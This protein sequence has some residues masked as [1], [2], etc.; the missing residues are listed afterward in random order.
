M[1]SGDNANSESYTVL[2]REMLETH[3]KHEREEQEQATN[4][5]SQFRIKNGCLQYNNKSDGEDRWEDV[6]S[7]IHVAA[8]TRN[9]RGEDWGRLLIFKDK[10]GREHKWAMPMEMLAGDGLEYR[11]RLL[12]MG[13]IIEPGKKARDRLYQ[14]IASDIPEARARAVTRIGWHD[15]AYVFPNEVI[16]QH[17]SLLFQSTASIHHAFEARGALEDWQREVGQLCSGNSRLLFAVSAAFAPTLLALLNFES[18]GFHFSGASS[19]G[20]T[21]ALAVAGSVWGGGGLRGYSRQWRATANGLEGVAALH[22]DALLCLDEISQVSA[23]AAGEVAY[24]LANGQGKSR[25]RRDGSERPPSEWRL[26]F[27]ST[28]EISLADKVAEDGRRRATAGQQVRVLDIP[29]DS[30]SGRG[31]FENTHDASD[32]AAFADKL[33]AGATK[34]YGTPIRAFLHQLIE[35]LEQATQVVRIAM[36]HFVATH[37][38]KGANGQVLRALDRFALVAAAGELSISFDV[39]PWEAGEAIDAAARCFQA[40]LDQR[41]GAGAAEIDA[42]IAQIRKFFELHGESRF[43]PWDGVADRPTLNRAGLRRATDSGIDFYVFPEV[44]KQ[45][46]CAGL[47][48][49][50]MAHVL[51]ERRYLISGSDGSAAASCSLPVLGKKRVYHFCHRILDDTE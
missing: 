41:G 4:T 42:G 10:D 5:E 16:G 32:G 19:V 2:A 18:S 45:E 49:R 11:Q 28:G 34:L 51:I 48:A 29:A 20:K 17:E 47:D 9:E 30:G 50:R 36:K 22:C 25:A 8:V 14:Y 21:T 33:R 13:L 37:R 27:L 40:W 24:L 15:S 46:L 3:P 23:Q 35:N 1:M 44:F 39:L 7:A 38:P 26:L 12:S 6:S 31:L 43:T